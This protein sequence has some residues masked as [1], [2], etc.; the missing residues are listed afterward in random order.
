MKKFIIVSSVFLYHMVSA[1]VIIGDEIGTASNKTSVLLE[2]ANTNNKGLILPYVK[3]LPSNVTPG[4]ILLDA[5]N[6]SHARV[7]YYNG[8]WQD[9]SGRDGDV[10]TALSQQ[11]NNGESSN[12]MVIIGS[13]S[14]SA[15]GVLVLESATKAMVLP[16]VSNVDNIPSP[17]PGMMVYVNK[18]GAKR[19]AFFN[20][21]VWSFWSAN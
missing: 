10:N 21:S 3:T 16:V 5:S 17:S 14:S 13:S 1:Q 6:G 20:G 2:F 18:A 11:P 12:G 4:T 7:K 15:D 19:L 8:A 9:L